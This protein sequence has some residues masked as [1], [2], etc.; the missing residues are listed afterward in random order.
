MHMPKISKNDKVLLLVMALG[1][2]VSL[3]FT[4]RAL[5][6]GQS[7]ESTAQTRERALRDRKAKLYNRLRYSEAIEIYK[8]RLKDDPD[9]VKPDIN[10]PRSIIRYIQKRGFVGKPHGAAASSAASSVDRNELREDL[11]RRIDRDN[12]KDTCP[13][14]LRS[15]NAGI[16]ELCRTLS[17]PVRGVRKRNRPEILRLIKR[18]NRNPARWQNG[19]N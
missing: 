4:A 10:D 12:Q 13:Q 17:S 5:I 18:Q 1:M 7:P 11:Q 3:P 9:A 15:A 14:T 6:S 19:S 8:Q 16:Y 2:V